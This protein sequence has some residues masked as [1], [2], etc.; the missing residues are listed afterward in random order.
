M[1]KGLARARLP[2]PDQ[3]G[4][5][6]NAVLTF[7]FFWCV[8]GYR[9]FV[10]AGIETVPIIERAVSSQYMK[11][12]YYL[13][14]IAD[15]VHHRYLYV[16]FLAAL[17]RLVGGVENAMLVAYLV[18]YALLFE[19]L[20]G[21]VKS[22][23]EFR[24][25]QLATML[26]ATLFLYYGLSRLSPGDVGLMPNETTSNLFARAILVS[27]LV[28][29][30]TART[31]LSLGLLVVAACFH[32]LEALLAYPVFAAL[33]VLGVRGASGVPGKAVILQAALW[34]LPLTAVVL[35][36]S[37]GTLMGE[38][39]PATVE[40]AFARRLNHHYLPTAWPWWSWIFAVSIAAAGTLSLRSRGLN[41]LAIA[42]LCSTGCF[43]IYLPALMLLGGTWLLSLQGAKVMMLPYVVWVLSIVAGLIGRGTQ[44]LQRLSLSR[45]Y[46]VTLVIV[47]GGGAIAAGV[48]AL[49]VLPPALLGH[50]QRQAESVL[51]FN[52]RTADSYV[53]NSEAG[54]YRWLASH[55]EPEAVIL[56]PPELQMIRPLAQRSSVVQAKLIGF[57]VPAM[58]Q[59][60]ERMDSLENYCR[61]D[62]GELREIAR[63][64]GADW[65][66]RPVYC[67]DAVGE[68]PAYANPDWLVL[69]TDTAK[70][71]P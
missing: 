21:F 30:M 8:A 61:R 43:V 18:S 19:R 7:A 66:V 46:A 36:F 4:D 45:G 23:S 17:A 62:I 47:L 12:D 29:A 70:T 67:P 49:A 38:N 5:Y 22:L 65:I 35:V 33:T 51:S 2:K 31:N 40:R 9:Y 11:N 56:H 20:S 71:K 1:N 58:R 68:E 15:T 41:G 27:G 34:F 50:A 10:N 25:V 39:D 6:R 14:L 16:E 63:R 59:W 54:L 26:V 60:L 28:A 42:C 69:R 32:P 37:S 44:G 55:T 3:S 13:N 52:Y 48:A 53:G 24:N 57:T 64:Y